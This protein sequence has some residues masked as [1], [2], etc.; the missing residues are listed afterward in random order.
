MRRFVSLSAALYA[1]AATLLLTACN[2]GGGTTIPAATHEVTASSVQS[3]AVA[4]IPIEAASAERSTES[5]GVATIGL[6]CNHGPPLHGPCI[7][8]VAI[9]VAGAYSGTIFLP[10]GS[11]TLTIVSSTTTGYVPLL[12]STPLLYVTVTARNAVVMNGTPGFTLSVPRAVGGL[13]NIADRGSHAWTKVEGPARVAN[14]Q[15]TFAPVPV[16]IK[17]AA[18]QSVLFALY[19]SSSPQPTHSAPPTAPPSHPSPTPVPTAAP[20]TNSV[21]GTV[22]DFVSGAA[23]SGFTVTVGAQPNGDTCMG[24][25]TSSSMPCG[26]PLAPI[27]TTTTAANGTFMLHGVPIATEMIMIAKD[28]TYATLHRTATLNAGVNALGTIKLTALDASHQAWLADWNNE[29]ATVSF[30]TSYANMVV[31]EYAQEGAAKWSSD[32]TASGG[33]LDD[34]AYESVYAAAYSALPGAMYSIG[35]VLANEPLGQGTDQF[36]IPDQ[37]WFNREKLNCPNGICQDGWYRKVI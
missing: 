32:L 21:S 5:N 15:V 2:G 26:V 7:E 33:L 11:G 28:G 29:R 9:P 8:S 3:P 18:R 22:V 34:S 31:D 23:L 36:Q 13:L 35:G 25:Q 4:S 17:L 1:L 20:V 14:G 12:Q 24:P 19:G 27:L 10:S 37:A 16:T 6:K 30:P